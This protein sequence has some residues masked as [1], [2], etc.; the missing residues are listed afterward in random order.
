MSA[1]AAE[2]ASFQVSSA[3]TLSVATR[4]AGVLVA[5]GYL[6]GVVPGPL[7]AVVGGMALMTYGRNLLL[8]RRP[9]IVS[10]AALAVVGGALGIAAL[11]WGA[12]E[13]GDIRG[14]QSVLGPTVLVGPTQAAVATGI[15]TGGA[16]VALAVWSSRPWPRTRLQAI[17]CA[18]E[19]IVGAFAIATVFLDPAESALGSG[20]AAEVA[21]QVARWVGVI[22]V[23]GAVVAGAA[24]LLQ[25]TADV[26]RA[27][28]VAVAAA[29][30]MTSAALILSVV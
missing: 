25:R 15:A 12:L 18:L 4:V 9:A 3:S 2:P 13:L 24:W 5:L 29:A 22:V 6:S 17:W 14:V 21:A 8:E 30:V 27:V 11:R 28:A 1:P 19:L 23:V 7:V 16:C 20:G 10:G 26:W